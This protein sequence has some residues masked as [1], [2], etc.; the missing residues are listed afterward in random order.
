VV[1][2]GQP[3]TEEVV[4]QF[5]E[6][7]A[8][9]ERVYRPHLKVDT[10][11]DEPT[12]VFDFHTAELTEASRTRLLF[13]AEAFMQVLSDRQSRISETARLGGAGM[14]MALHN[15]LLWEEQEAVIA[16]A[17]GD[18][19]VVDQHARQKYPDADESTI[20]GLAELEVMVAAA[21]FWTVEAADVTE[22]AKRLA[23][24]AMSRSLWQQLPRVQ[25]ELS[26]RIPG[27]ATP[28]I[29]TTG[30]CLLPT[31]VLISLLALAA[32]LSG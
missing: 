22:R 20:R 31:T 8:W 14:L 27:I 6:A 10:E 19:S 3:S 28:A 13:F 26:D 21:G 18:W 25:K 2:E 29:R 1:D 17:V 9:F 15:A 24:L 4:R 32:F 7:L 12:A 16:A 30:G 11:A 23:P 5:E